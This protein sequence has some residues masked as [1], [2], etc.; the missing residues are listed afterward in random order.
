MNFKKINL[1]INEMFEKGEF[2]NDFINTNIYTLF[3][4]QLNNKLKTI[5]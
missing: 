4:N 2:D 5:R 3:K 1:R